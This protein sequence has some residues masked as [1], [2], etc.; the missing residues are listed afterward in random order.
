MSKQVIVVGA[1]LGGLAAAA[2]LAASGLEVEVFEKNEHL[3]GKLNLLEQD[4]FTFDLGPS[5]IILP[6][7][8]RRVFER[9]GRNMDDYVRL[10][11]L[12]PQWRSFF[13]D[14]TVIDLH[15]DMARMEEELAKLGSS[16]RGYWRFIEYS[17]RLYQFS[18]EAYLERGADTVRELLRGHGVRETLRGIDS[19]STLHQGVARHVKEPH[20]RDMLDFFVKYVGSSAYDAPAMLNMLPYSQ[21]GWGLWYVEGGMYNLARG[22]AR[23]LDE[24]GVQVHLGAEVTQIVRSG[25]RVQGVVVRGDSATHRADYVVSNME[26]IPAY[27][28]LLNLRDHPLLARYEKRFEP[29]SSGLVVHLGVDR[30]YPQLTHHNFFFSR[31][32][33]SFWHQVHHDKHLPDDPTLHVVYPS[34]SNDALAPEGQHVLMVLSHVPYGQDSPFTAADYQALEDRVLA[35]LERMGLTDLR[36]HVVTKH[37]LVPEDLERLYRSNHGAI[38]G[39]VSHRT[40]NFAL[41]AP[42]QSELYPNLY[43]VGGSVNPG[44][45][46]PMVTL[47]GQLVAAHIAREAAGQD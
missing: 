34:V 36:K 38:Y 4:G 6:H 3:G 27:R 7:L 2:S 15:P 20:L 5:V 13:E 37:V 30:A 1:G 28:D 41:K 33:E 47:S 40:K 46:T 43:F 29:A 8:L 21:L 44:G 39:V 24:L 12:T 32:Q 25:A 14:G 45:G 42:K 18:E 17:R 9:A 10:V 26:V 23:L 22:Y 19:F 11:E 31:D 35:K 16:S